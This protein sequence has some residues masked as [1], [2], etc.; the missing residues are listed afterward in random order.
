MNRVGNVLRYAIG[1]IFILGGLGGIS[2]ND[3]GGIFCALFGISLF[4]ILYKKM[5]KNKILP[6]AIPIVLI[7]ISFFT[8]GKPISSKKAGNE[9]YEPINQITNSSQNI[10]KI[11][12]DEL[13]F[14]KTDIQLDL[15]ESE[16]IELTYLPNDATQK[17]VEISVSDENVLA[18]EKKC[19]QDKIKIKLIPLK[20]GICTI[21]AKTKKDV[22]SNEIKI[23]IIDKERIEREEAE[24]KAKEEEEKKAKEETEKRARQEQ[25]QREKEER[26]KSQKSNSKQKSS[27]SSSSI[28]DE[29]ETTVYVT[30]TGKRYHY[31]P[32]CG[33]KN[34]TKATLDE[35]KARGLTPCKKCAQ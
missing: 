6:I 17:D 8:I 5:E 31:S 30:P 25:E 4:P 15:K 3:T 23:E 11:E 19:E 13:K 28:Y 7:I 21:F 10:E 18:V 16:Y 12:I 14:V 34:S 27:N 1:I 2:V 20:E 32:T 35:A 22:K 9:F 29:N 24:K 33:G 26:E